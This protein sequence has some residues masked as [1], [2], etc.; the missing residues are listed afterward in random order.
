[1]SSDQIELG[2]TLRG[3]SRPLFTL[4]GSGKDCQW[5]NYN[6]AGHERMVFA[7]GFEVV[8]RMRPYTV[9]FNIHP[10][11]PMTPRN[12]A[13]AVARRLLTHGDAPGVLHQALLAR[14]RVSDPEGAPP[15][16]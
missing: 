5:F 6:A 1:M 2:L 15:R 12:A 8:Q 9:R 13:R 11:P 10:I 16:T 14:P 3:R 7:A 4:N